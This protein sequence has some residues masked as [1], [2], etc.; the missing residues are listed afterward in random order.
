[1]TGAKKEVRG[2]HAVDGRKAKG[3]HAVV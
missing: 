1:L 2:E 3:E